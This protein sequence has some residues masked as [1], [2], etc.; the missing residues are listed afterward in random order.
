LLMQVTNSPNVF[1]DQG[2]FSDPDFI[3]AT[4]IRENVQFANKLI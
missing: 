2:Q 4:Y 1:V 3:N